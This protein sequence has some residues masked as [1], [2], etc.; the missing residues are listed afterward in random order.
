MYRLVLV[1]V[2]VAV[3]TSEQHLKI[4][5]RTVN[6]WED[7]FGKNYPLTQCNVY[8][9]SSY[10]TLTRI[11][12]TRGWD[13]IKRVLMVDGALQKLCGEGSR[14]L[15]CVSN[16]VKRVPEECKQEYSYQAFGP[17]NI[18]NLDKGV[19][20]IEQFC[21]DENIEIATRNLDCV[22]NDC[23]YS[24]LY[25]CSLKNPDKDCS[26]LQHLNYEL[27]DETRECVNEMYR[28]NCDA[29]DVVQCA[30][31]KVSKA[32]TA[33]V[34]PLVTL[35]GN[36]VFEIMPICRGGEHKFRTLLKFFK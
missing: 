20:L 23:I 1:L 19:E 25:P 13:R 15:T 26:H 8:N 9:A 14:L 24:K 16:S 18:S 3:T 29:A 21:T 27:S 32:C 17:L 6:I 31:N 2:L 28:R 4:E 30:A 5:R 10:P 11:Y 7:C 35:A 12:R 34:G 22:V 36:G 33:E